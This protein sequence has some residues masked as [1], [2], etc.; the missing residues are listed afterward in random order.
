MSPL[1]KH[2]THPE[3]PN[4]V[5]SA[6]DVED[7]MRKYDK[8]SNTR[9]W[10]GTP[11]VI[12]R[13]VM[14]FFSLYCIWSTLFSVAALEKRLTAFL[15]L[16]VIMGYLIYPAS[17]HHVRHNYIPWYDYVIMVLGAACFLYYYFSYDSLVTVLTSF[18]RMSTLQVAREPSRITE[19]WLSV[20]LTK[21]TSVRY[22]LASAT[23]SSIW[24]PLGGPTSAV[25][26]NSPLSKSSVILISVTPIR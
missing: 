14:V 19:D 13:M 20:T 18:S 17:K 2:D 5:G 25:T 8:E 22:S 11:A 9:I 7:L 1:F 15:A 24:M 21:W 3:D 4:T 6:K 12:V 16:L 23:I 10:E 26:T